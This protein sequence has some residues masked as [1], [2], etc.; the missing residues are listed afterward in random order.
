MKQYLVL[1]VMVLAFTPTI[2]VEAQDYSKMNLHFVYIDHETSTPVN[3][4][5]KRIRTLRDDAIE[6]EDALVI[7]L[8]DGRQSLMSFTNLKD[9]NDEN[10]DTNEAFVNIIAALQDANSHDVIA[11]E[12]RKNILKLFDDYNFIDEQGHFLFNSVTM[13][14]YIGPDFWN[15]GNHEKVIAHLFVDFDVSSFAK[16]K[17][18][19]NIFKPKGVDLKYPEGMPFGENNIEGINQKLSIFEY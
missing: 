11:R 1:I 2:S 15:L 5:C 12:D 18:A 8:S 3:Q 19:I 16:T 4:L 10:R 9:F 13:D 17:L 6:V 14:F 7:Y